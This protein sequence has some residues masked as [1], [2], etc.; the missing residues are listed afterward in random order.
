V[1]LVI[2]HLG[3]L[4]A[5]WPDFPTGTHPNGSWYALIVSIQRG[6]ATVLTA[7]DSLIVV[8]TTAALPAVV[9]AL[10]G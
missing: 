6:G 9:S 3:Y 8:A 4:G 1:R 5:D 7:G 10:Q 2:P